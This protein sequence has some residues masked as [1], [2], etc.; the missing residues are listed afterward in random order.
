MASVYKKRG[1]WW[2]RV[3]DA[4]GVWRDRPAKASTK[5]AARREAL[6]AQQL[7]ER[8]RN[9][10]APSSENLR[11]TFGELMDLWRDRYGRR[12]RGPTIIGMAE[13]HLRPTLGKLPLGGAAAALGPLLAS[14]T[15]ELSPSSLNHLRAYA[16][17]LY[18]IAS[19][20]S[21]GWWARPNPVNR[22]ELP[23]FKEPKRK[24]QTLAADDVPALL[25]VLAAEWR[26]LFATA[27]FLGLRRG[28]LIALRKD[29]VDLDVGT[30][31][32]AR[33]LDAETTKGGNT[34]TL[35]IPEPLLPYLESA[36]RSTRSEWLFPK[37]DGTQRSLDLDVTAVLRR[38]LGRAGIVEGYEHRCRKPRCGHIERTADDAQR[39]C[40]NDG[41]A[42]WL[43]PLPRRLSFHSLRH[44]CAT[45]LAKAGVH[46][47]VAQQILRHAD[48][49]TTLAI[50]THI[51]LGDMR[52]AL[53]R[54]F[55]ANLLPTGSDPK[56]E[57]R[58][59][60]PFSEEDRGL[61]LVGATGFEPATTCTPS[62][63]ATRLRYAPEEAREVSPDSGGVNANC[64]CQNPSESTVFP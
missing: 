51:D 10:L 27:L 43:R 34:V 62:K 54:T 11:R 52:D 13:K 26:P 20:P 2:F 23:K 14:K 12:L 64:Q 40:P 21:V 49:E 4:T 36:V 58:D 7:A 16:H 33:S 24:P 8:Q 30:L 47:K 3:R 60:S 39:W 59:R 17:R 25:A 48:V 57:A 9:G 61:R 29:D 38:A 28:E 53:S 19:L 31:T 44:T 45:L 35:P 63:C 42:L 15:E 46:P 37:P 1:T 6:E 32:V 41:R 22:D 5:P 18:A 55:A 50:Y 56:G